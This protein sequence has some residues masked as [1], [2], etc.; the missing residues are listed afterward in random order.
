MT[1][2][3]ITNNNDEQTETAAPV[4]SDDT[5][6]NEGAS[7]SGETNLDETAEKELK[8]SALGIA[9]VVLSVL[10]LIFW[11]FF[12]LSSVIIAKTNTFGNEGFD[13]WMIMK[14][15]ALKGFI[16]ANIGLLFGVMAML[17]KNTRKRAAIF[18]IAINGILAMIFLFIT[19][20]TSQ[21]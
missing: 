18:G 15:F 10:L 2:D 16:T 1:S 13:I 11:L 21:S 14:G 9:S 4:L 8:N 5:A 3:D 6:L 12:I 17:F 20:V 7:E 19:V